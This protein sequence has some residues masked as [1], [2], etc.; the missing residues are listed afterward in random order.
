MFTQHFFLHIEILKSLFMH[1]IV[2]QSLDGSIILRIN[3]QMAAHYHISIPRWQ[4]SYGLIIWGLT[5]EIAAQLLYSNHQMAAQDYISISRWQHN[6]YFN[7]QMAA[8]YHFS[9]LDGSTISWVN[10]QMA[11]QYCIWVNPQMAAQYYISFPRWQHNFTNQ[12][13]DGSTI[14]YFNH[15]S[16]ISIPRWQHN[17]MG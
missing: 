9:T 13:P 6:I 1:N 15:Q 4:Q 5:R 7:H 8:Q 10:L 14:L 17:L 11:A 3:H 2:F 12:S 16:H